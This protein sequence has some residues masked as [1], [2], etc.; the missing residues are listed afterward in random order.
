MLESGH[1]ATKKKKKS[2][3]NQDQKQEH[4]IYSECVQQDRQAML[5]DINV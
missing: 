1:R 3:T 5:R 4:E 2:E